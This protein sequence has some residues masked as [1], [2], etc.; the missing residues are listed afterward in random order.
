MAS[1]ARQLLLAALLGVGMGVA[2]GACNSSEV[3]LET[4]GEGAAEDYGC[5]LGDLGCGCA[6]GDM[7]D[8]HLTC[9]QGTCVCI[10]PECMEMPPMTTAETGMETTG[11]ETGDGDGDG[12]GTP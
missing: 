3:S 12:D 7:C 9:Q 4:Y 6:A 11:T 5:I 1:P 2:L 10:T 8:N